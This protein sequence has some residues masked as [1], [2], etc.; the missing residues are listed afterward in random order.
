MAAK[1]EDTEFRYPPPA[2]CGLP[3]RA[4]QLLFLLL[5]KGKRPIEQGRGLRTGRC[6][7]GPWA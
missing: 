3:A 5:L 7:P 4:D 6:G 2:C 1:G